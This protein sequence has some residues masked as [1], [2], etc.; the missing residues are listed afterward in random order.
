MPQTFTT[1]AVPPAR[2]QRLVCDACGSAC[3]ILLV[4][5]SIDPETGYQEQLQFCKACF[6]AR[7]QR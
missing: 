6:K 3:D 1:K 4:A 5:D 7:D 2:E